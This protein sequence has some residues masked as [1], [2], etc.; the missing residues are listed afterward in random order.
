MMSHCWTIKVSGSFVLYCERRSVLD[1]DSIVLVSARTHKILCIRGLQFN[2]P[3]YSGFI[4]LVCCYFFSLGFFLCAAS[5]PAGDSIPAVFYP[6]LL[7]FCTLWLLA[8]SKL[9]L[10]CRVLVLMASAVMEEP[11]VLCC[12]LSFLSQWGKW[13]PCPLLRVLP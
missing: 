8:T 7:C 9:H 2:K 4:V 5:L 1:Q 11:A 3:C 13:F 12:H 6:K 10:P